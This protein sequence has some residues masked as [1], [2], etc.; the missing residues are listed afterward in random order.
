MGNKNKVQINVDRFGADEKPADTSV[1]KAAAEKA[2]AP[3]VIKNPGLLVS[4]ADHPIEVKYGESSI[5][6]S[7]RQ[8][9]EIA[10]MS[11][12]DRQSLSPLVTVITK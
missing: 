10:D 7:P 2:D 12:V 3:V 9:V 5:R 8:R 4:R 1:L 11:L 6:L